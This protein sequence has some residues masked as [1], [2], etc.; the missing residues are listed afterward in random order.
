MRRALTSGIIHGRDDQLMRPIAKCRIVRDTVIVTLKGNT[1][2]IPIFNLH[3]SMIHAEELIGLSITQA[4]A[5]RAKR[6]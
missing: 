3:G 5:L 4:R 1:E 2:D 6:Y